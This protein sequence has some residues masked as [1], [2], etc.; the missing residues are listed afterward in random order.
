MGIR[1]R[2]GGLRSWGASLRYT[3]D[4]L[5]FTIDYRRNFTRDRDVKPEDILLVRIIFRTLG[6]VG[7]VF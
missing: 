7:T 1:G 5:D 4:C 2:D 6:E 3:C